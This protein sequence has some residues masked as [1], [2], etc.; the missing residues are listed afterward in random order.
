L[1]E[2]LDAFK[3]AT[4]LYKIR[5]LEEFKEQIPLYSYSS[6]NKSYSESKMLMG[7]YIQEED[8]YSELLRLQPDLLEWI[9]SNLNEKGEPIRIAFLKSLE[10]LLDTLG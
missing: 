3:K 4:L 6:L 1:Q 2:K 9:L 7:Q 5:T 10:F 8:I